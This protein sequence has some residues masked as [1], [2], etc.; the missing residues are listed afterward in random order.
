MSDL[1]PEERTQLAIKNIRL[2]ALEIVF[3]IDWWKHYHNVDA[4]TKIGKQLWSITKEL[5]YLRRVT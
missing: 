1:T 2:C 4:L 3:Q 5:I